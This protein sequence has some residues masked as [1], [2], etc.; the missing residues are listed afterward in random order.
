MPYEPQLDDSMAILPSRQLV[1]A[2]P[3]CCSTRFSLMP[4]CAIWAAAA[5]RMLRGG[6]EITRSSVMPLGYPADASS[7]LAR[8][9]SNL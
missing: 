4:A 9:G 5:S 1:I 8:A 7:C 2:V 3:Y 6:A